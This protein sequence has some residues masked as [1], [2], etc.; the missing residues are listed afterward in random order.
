MIMESESMEHDPEPL[1]VR[2]GEYDPYQVQELYP[3]W[4][5]VKVRCESGRP[6][7]NRGRGRKTWVGMFVCAIA[8]DVQMGVMPRRGGPLPF[9][10]RPEGAEWMGLLMPSTRHVK[11]AQRLDDETPLGQL[12]IE[13]GHASPSTDAPGT[14]YKRWPVPLPSS[15][16]GQVIVGGPDG[17]AGYR[18][19]LEDFRDGHP[20]FLFRCECGATFPPLLQ[21]KVKSVF[22]ELR[23]HGVGEVSIQKLVTLT[24]HM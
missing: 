20:V 14:K 19:A 11:D 21:D 15:T 6:W 3:Y 16:M 17:F 2:A 1:T 23:L 4:G 5:M 18:G 12:E 10:E 22:D 8:I 7:H 24:A 13:T 9:N